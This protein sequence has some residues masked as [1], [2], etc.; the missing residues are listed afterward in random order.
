MTTSA[1]SGFI[2]NG[3]VYVN[4]T[5]PGMYIPVPTTVE[6]GFTEHGW[7]FPTDGV[8]MLTKVLSDG[9]DRSRHEDIT[10]SGA[11][12]K[13]DGKFYDI[14]LAGPHYRLVCAHGTAPVMVFPEDKESSLVASFIEHL[15]LNPELDPE[16]GVWTPE[17]IIKILGHFPGN[18]N[19]SPYI[20]LE[21]LIAKVKERGSKAF[22]DFPRG[23]AE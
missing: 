21:E 15:S 17:R 23:P 18:H 10:Y 11:L 13:D 7:W 9:N 12:L 3:M 2:V 5:Q 19:F 20:P 1:I 4:R 6:D 8:H 22:A 14:R 16:G